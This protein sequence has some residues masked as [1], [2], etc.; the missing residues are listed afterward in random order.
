MPIKV[1]HFVEQTELHMTKHVLMIVLYVLIR[2]LYGG[3]K[4]V[5]VPK[6]FTNQTT[7]KVLIMEW[8]EVILHIRSLAPYLALS[9]N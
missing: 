3:I 4:D 1:T 8:L 9:V 6:M 5:I 2:E 7:R